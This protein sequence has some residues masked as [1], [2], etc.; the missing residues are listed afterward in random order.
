MKFA[1]RQFLHLAAGAAAAP[2]A[3]HVAKQVAS[4]EVVVWGSGQRA[5]GV[6]RS[7]LNGPLTW[8]KQRALAARGFWGC[9]HWGE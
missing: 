6:H 1:R 8:K 5:V 4:L 7:V 9:N 2:A 3:P